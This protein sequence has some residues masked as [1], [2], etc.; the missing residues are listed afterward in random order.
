[1]DFIID[2]YFKEEYLTCGR[3]RDNFIFPNCSKEFICFAQDSLK[4]DAHG[5]KSCCLCID[6]KV[7]EKVEEI[8][9]QCKNELQRKI[10]ARDFVCTLILSEVFKREDKA[11][12]R[13]AELK[14]MEDIFTAGDFDKYIASHHLCPFPL[15]ISSAVKKY[16]NIELNIFLIDMQSNDIQKA[17][18]NFISSREPYSIKLF[19][20]GE[21]LSTYMDQMGNRIE[22]PHDYMTLEIAKYIT[23]DKECGDIESE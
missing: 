9:K 20:T 13:L 11:V 14:D 2:D 16:G 7:Q 8:L 1:M 19:T 10:V 5:K 21:R 15:E 22:W 17:I 23:Y 6:R 3:T 18:N 4:I 12:D